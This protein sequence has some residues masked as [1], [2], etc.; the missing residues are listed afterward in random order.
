MTNKPDMKLHTQLLKIGHDIEKKD[1]HGLEDV[2]IDGIISTFDFMGAG[3]DHIQQ[4]IY[5]L[6]AARYK[7][8]DWLGMMYT[9][10]Y[11]TGD[12][13]DDIVFKVVEMMVKHYV[14]MKDVG[15]WV[16]S[17]RGHI[18]LQVE[19]DVKKP[20]ANGIHCQDCIDSYKGWHEEMIAAK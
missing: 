17:Y 3:A 18:D 15:G 1:T 14:A 4:M 6:K 16:W 8:F 13:S 20:Y 12:T 5:D 10:R 9:G 19:M 7:I 11:K 2:M